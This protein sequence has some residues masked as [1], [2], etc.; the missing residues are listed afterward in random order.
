MGGSWWARFTLI[1]TVFAIAQYEMMPTFLGKDAVERF[2]EQARTAEGVE[3]SGEVAEGYATGDIAVVLEEE[4]IP[5]L[6]T[7]F[8][9]EWVEDVNYYGSAKEDR[10]EIKV[11]EEREG[12]Q[13]RRTPRRDAAMREAEASQAQMRGGAHESA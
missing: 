9:D 10:L 7:A 5:R 6:K 4:A 12:A 3:L 11:A 13:E 1:L 8:G 2:K